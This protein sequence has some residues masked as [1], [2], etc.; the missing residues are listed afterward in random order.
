MNAFGFPYER[1]I[2]DDHI[3]IILSDDING[4]GECKNV[5][6][7]ALFSDNY[8]QNS[9]SIDDGS[10]PPAFCADTIIEAF[11]APM[12]APAAIFVCSQRATTLQYKNCL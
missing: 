7:K 5:F 6:G 3:A 12:E 11:R 2:T 10:A 8:N 9:S 4:N 1:E